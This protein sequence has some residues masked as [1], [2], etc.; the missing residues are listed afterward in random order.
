MYY[1]IKHLVIF[2]VFVVVLSFITNYIVYNESFK[3]YKILPYGEVYS[4]NDPLYFYRYDRYRKPYNWPYLYHSSY[5]Y[6][7][8][9]PGR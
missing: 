6:P 2:I 8:M 4:G 7:H 9:E 1:L 5:P 3:D